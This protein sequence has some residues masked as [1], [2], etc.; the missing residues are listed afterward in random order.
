MAHNIV[1]PKYTTVARNNVTFV[2]KTICADGDANSVLQIQIKDSAY[3]DGATFK[4]AMSGVMLYYELAEEIITDIE[5]P[6]ELT[7]WLEVEAGGSVTFKNADET[8]QL[9]VPNAV[10][11]VRK[12]DE[13][14]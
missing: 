1:C 11:L 8:K 9:T 6:T 2:D 3:T 14:E 12:L 4:L 7:D 5:I 13:V 10:S